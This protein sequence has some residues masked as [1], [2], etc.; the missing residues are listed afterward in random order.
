ML[1]YAKCHHRLVFN[2]FVG[3]TSDMKKKITKSSFAF[4]FSIQDGRESVLSTR[5]GLRR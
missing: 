3:D 4:Y 1:Y 2:S 5:D